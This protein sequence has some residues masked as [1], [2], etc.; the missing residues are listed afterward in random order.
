MKLNSRKVVTV[1]T[2]GFGLGIGS[3]V[4]AGNTQSDHT[5]GSDVCRNGDVFKISSGTPETILDNGGGNPI[6]AGTS[7]YA[8]ALLASECDGD[9]TFEYLGSGDAGLQNRFYVNGELVFDTKTSEIGDK[10]KVY[11]SADEFAPHSPFHFQTDA[12]GNGPSVFNGEGPLTG[13]YAATSYKNVSIFYAIEGGATPTATA[14]RTVFLGLTDGFVNSAGTADNDHQDLGVKISFRRAR[15][16]H[17]WND[18]S[19]SGHGGGYGGSSD[20]GSRRK[21]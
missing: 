19:W 12:A 21:H 6:P 2:L 18:N 5:Q 14:G 10:Y 4:Q 13:T 8:D 3:P 16:W 11:L 17:H 7:G 9:Y 1:F 15:H 20:Y